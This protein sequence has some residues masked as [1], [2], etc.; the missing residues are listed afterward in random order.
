MKQRQESGAADDAMKRISVGQMIRDELR[1]QER[2]VSWFARRLSCDRTNVYRIFGKDS[3]DTDLLLRI[4]AIL[5]H[6]F[7]DDIS[8]ATSDDTSTE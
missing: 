7:F 1:R 3:I 5:H 4:S 6:D 2:G 8:R